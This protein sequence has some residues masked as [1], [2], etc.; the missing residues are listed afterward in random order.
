MKEE[1]LIFRLIKKFPFIL[2]IPESNLK[3]SLYRL[4]EYEFTV[5]E[6][7]SFIKLFPLYLHLNPNG[8]LMNFSYLESAGLSRSKIRKIVISNPFILSIEHNT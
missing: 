2:N 8:T 7:F 6:I 5:D 4:L 1:K 3:L